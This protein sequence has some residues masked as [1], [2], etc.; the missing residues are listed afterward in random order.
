MHRRTVEQALAIERD[1]AEPTADRRTGPEAAL[2]YAEHA[3]FLW[4]SL[5][6]MGI[7]EADLEDAVQEVLVVVHR[8]R[9]SYNYECRLTTWLFGICLRVASRHRRRAYFRWERHEAELPELIDHHTP[10]DQLIEHR[11][12]ATLNR[13]LSGLRPEHRAAF[14]LFEIE[15]QSCQDIAELSGVPVGTI[16]SR[17]HKARQ[18]VDRALER[19][20]LSARKGHDR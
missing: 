10:E 8:R 4:R 16:Y 19:E 11:T 7:R 20:R 6:H 2:V 9:G 3:E 13:L 1:V 17:L 5:Q 18:L 12:K 14:V 15:G